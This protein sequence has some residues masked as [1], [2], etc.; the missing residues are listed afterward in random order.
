MYSLPAMMRALNTLPISTRTRGIDY[1]N[2]ALIEPIADW[3]L[4][5]V[6]VERMKKGALRS[7]DARKEFLDNLAQEMGV[8]AP[9][10]PEGRVTWLSTDSLLP[11]E[12]VDSSRAAEL[13]E[14][15]R[16]AVSIP[17]IVVEKENRIVIDGHHRLHALRALGRKTV[18][19][20]L[21]D[22]EFSWAWS[23]L[24]ATLSSTPMP[25]HPDTSPESDI[26]I[27]GSTTKEEVMS[28]GKSGKLLP[29]KSSRHVLLSSGDPVV[30][31]SSL[32]PL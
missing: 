25:F 10:C 31:L 9:S 19:C 17:A 2:N 18:P 4:D 3:F 23:D 32:A 5:P 30:V 24:H 16:D 22:C 13:L 11:H 26:T 28:A 14:Y 21:V 29:P 7:F 27:D 6:K 20:I 15:Y 8:I 1:H 12:E